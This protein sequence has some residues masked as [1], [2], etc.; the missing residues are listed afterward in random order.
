MS[1]QIA[2]ELR[3]ELDYGLVY[4]NKSFKAETEN[5]SLAMARIKEARMAIE[6]YGF[7]A[8]SDNP[9]PNAAIPENNIIEFPTDDVDSDIVESNQEYSEL[10][11]L[12][13]LVKGFI[14]GF[15]KIAGIRTSRL[16]IKDPSKMFLAMKSID[17]AIDRTEEAIQ[18]LILDLQRLSK[19]NP[20]KYPVAEEVILDK[21]ER[22]A[23]EE[24]VT[25][26]KIME[27]RAGVVPG[28]DLEESSNSPSS[29]DSSQTEESVS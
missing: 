12:K 11:H 29:E 22:V 4:M 9:Y 5:R 20:G 2:N 8:G 17:R 1:V 16:Q 13:F 7:Y 26:D 6:R 10:Q 23:P 3:V 19:E 14:M 18:Y 15:E 24:A 28:K 27:E 25:T 21:E